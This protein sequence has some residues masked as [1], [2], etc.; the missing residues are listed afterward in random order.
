MKEGRARKRFRPAY[1]KCKVSNTGPSWCTLPKRLPGE[2]AC[3]RCGWETWW[4]SQI[5]I[6]EAAL[7]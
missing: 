1:F 7:G 2:N 4:G 6:P 5:V 3:G